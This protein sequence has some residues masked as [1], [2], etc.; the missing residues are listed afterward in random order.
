[1]PET[2][3]TIGVAIPTRDR[4]EFL[5]ETLRSVLSGTRRPDTLCVVDNS[6]GDPAST[7]A[8]CEQFSGDVE[9]LA[10]V[11]NLTMQANHNRALR[12]FETTFACILHD[13]DRY[14]ASFLERGESAL[15]ND[16]DLALF[17]VNYRVID[18]SGATIMETCWSDFPT[19]RLTPRAYLSHSMPALSPIHLSAAMM[20]TSHAQRHELAEADGNCTDMGYFFRLAS[21][22]DILLVNEPLADVRLHGGMESVAVG[23][24]GFGR[25]KASELLPRV[26]LEFATKNRYLRSPLAAEVL[27]PLRWTLRRAAAKRAATLLGYEARNS[28]LAFGQR[29]RAA[30]AA[31]GLLPVIA[32]R[33]ETR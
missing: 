16:A 23:L 10:P 7:R 9:Y 11:G 5:A 4:P 13:D 2:G 27:G 3:T 21:H 30:K 19:G 28:S 18:G 25:G 12:S 24:Y 26:P 20:R 22:A 17:A 29:L 14:G 32:G 6:Q 31:A 1:M 33:G 15:V 8:V